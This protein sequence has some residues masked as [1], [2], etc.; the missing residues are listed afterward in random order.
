MYQEITKLKYLCNSTLKP[1]YILSISSSL[2]FLTENQMVG[3]NTTRTRKVS[4]RLWLPS[5]QLQ[6]YMIWN[7]WM[8]NVKGPEYHHYPFVKLGFLTLAL[9]IRQTF[10]P[11]SWQIWVKENFPFTGKST[12]PPKKKQHRADTSVISLLFPRFTT[13]VF[14]HF[15]LRRAKG[16]RSLELHTN[17]CPCT[18]RDVRSGEETFPHNS[19]EV[20]VNV[21]WLFWC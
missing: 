10:P 7:T 14:S 6:I 13:H 12:D 19:N 16:E 21:N 20:L 18:K 2:H 8:R 11:K 1:V 9:S 3:G 4:K 15:L 5:S 17:G